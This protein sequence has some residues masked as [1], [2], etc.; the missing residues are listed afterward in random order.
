MP[1]EKTDYNQIV[2]IATAFSAIA[3]AF[4]VLF[5]AITLILEYRWRRRKYAIDLLSAWND[6]TADHAK[7]ILSVFSDMRYGVTIDKDVGVIVFCCEKGHRYWDVR[8][9][10]VE[11]LN[12]AEAIAVAL[13]SRLAAKGI[14]AKSVNPALCNW[15]KNLKG[16]IDAVND[17][18]GSRP[19]ERFE[20][21]I[22]GLRSRDSCFCRQSIVQFHVAAKPTSR[23]LF[24]SSKPANKQSCKIAG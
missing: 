21:Y 12:H 9:H 20:I 8:F 4:S 5:L 6:C 17:I 14:L 23:F 16:F 18:K 13:D 1:V 19:W 7:E 11:L 10:M 2:A 24:P 15:Y 22:E 3:A